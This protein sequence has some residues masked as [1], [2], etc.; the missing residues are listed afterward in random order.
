MKALIIRIVALAALAS[1]L[2]APAFAAE[3]PPSLA[4]DVAAG[5][6]P[7]VTERLPRVPLVFT[8]PRSDTTTGSGCGRSSSRRAR[9]SP[10]GTAM[11]AS[12]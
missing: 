10:S 3:E 9:R 7:P 12:K 5:K 2:A 11:I 1:T 4:A 6:L 8:A